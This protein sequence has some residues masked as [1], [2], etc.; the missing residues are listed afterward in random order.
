MSYAFVPGLQ[1]RSASKKAA[2]SA[3]RSCIENYKLDEGLTEEGNLEPGQDKLETGQ[4]KRKAHPTVPCTVMTES[5]WER[6]ARNWGN[7][8]G[9]RAVDGFNSLPTL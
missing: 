9:W 1:A 6:E 4:R 3:T 7:G 2:D 8:V 5:V